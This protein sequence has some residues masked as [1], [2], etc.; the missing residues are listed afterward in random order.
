MKNSKLLFLLALMTFAVDARAD[1]LES[2]LKL[3]GKWAAILAALCFIAERKYSKYLE[4]QEI[5]VLLD[6]TDVIAKFTRVEWSAFGNDRQYVF[7]ELLVKI[8]EGESFTY[9]AGLHFPNGLAEKYKME[10][11]VGQTCRGR[12]DPNRPKKTLVLREAWATQQ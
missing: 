2:T 8:T 5:R 9:K 4:A 10:M 7:F 3:V 1:D 12:V 6:G 11:K